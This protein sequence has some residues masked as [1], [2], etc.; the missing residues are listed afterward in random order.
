MKLHSLLNTLAKI[1]IGLLLSLA[2][3]AQSI[4]I[5][6]PPK[7]KKDFSDTEKCVA[8][9]DIIR[10]NHASFLQHQRNDTMRRGIRTTKHS[11]VNCINCHVTQDSDGN[12]P[13]IKE[14]SEHFCRSCHTY[15]AVN[16]DCFQCHASIPTESDISIIP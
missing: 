16:I 2:V 3:S 12:Y 9:I 14:G 11:L 7:A 13:N 5:P 8:P 6:H 15:A 4:T 1:S 10:R